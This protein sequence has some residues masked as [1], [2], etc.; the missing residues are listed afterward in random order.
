MIKKNIFK[1]YIDKNF[2]KIDKQSI[3]KYRIK[4]QIYN[5]KSENDEILLKLL[6]NIFFEICT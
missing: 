3:N 4:K 1:K 2:K 6:K 5:L